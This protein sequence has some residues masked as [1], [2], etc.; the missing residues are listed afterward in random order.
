MRL[1]KVLTLLLFSTALTTVRAQLF[2]P[3]NLIKKDMESLVYGVQAGDF[4]MDGDQD[5]LFVEFDRVYWTENINGEGSFGDDFGIDSNRGQSLSQLVIDLDKDNFIDIII[6][7]FD[8]DSVEWYRNL[9]DGTFS[10]AQILANNLNA[11]RGITAG[12]IDDDGDLDLVLGVT[13]G[14]GFYWI[15][16]LDGNGT[17]G[18]LQTIDAGIA[19]ARTQRLGDIDGDGDL[20]VVTNGLGTERLSWF[21]NTDGAGNFSV[22]HIIEPNGLY[23]N[24]FELADL[25]GDDDLDIVSSKDKSLIWRENTDGLGTYGAPTTLFTDTM[26]GFGV[27]GFVSIVLIDL[28]NDNDIDITYD[29]GFWYGKV[30]QLNIDGAGTF[31]A[32]EFILPPEGGSTSYN[33]AADMDGDGDMDLLN[34]SLFTDTDLRD[35]YW[36]ENTTIL[37]SPSFLQPKVQLTPNPV[38]EILSVSNAEVIQ[39]MHFYQLY[40]SLVLGVSE[41]FETIDLS[42]LSEGM[43]MVHVK[44]AQGTDV[45]K[46][47]KK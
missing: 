12:D 34:N 10:E 47:I 42:K 23:E 16:H 39:E 45:H 38:G 20:D 13:N 31:S 6:S 22:Q 4:D 44:T 46:L 36:Y 32:P 9:G 18:P 43:Y 24:F 8:D 17:F 33:Y 11:A 40:G 29:S 26:S 15:E 28:D 2:G 30:Y 21:E 14:N 3:Q 37:G 41:N 27:G 7:Y 1:N 25:D 19:Q 35:Q 5:I